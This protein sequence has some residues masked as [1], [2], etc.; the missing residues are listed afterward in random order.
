MKHYFLYVFSLLEKI[1][2]GMVNSYYVYKL[3]NCGLETFSKQ[4][5]LR[6]YRLEGG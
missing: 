1:R 6:T 3:L 4:L 2:R 5:Y